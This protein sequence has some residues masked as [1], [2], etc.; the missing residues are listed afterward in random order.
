MKRAWG[1]DERF[2]EIRSLVWYT[3][4]MS[5]Q[6]VRDNLELHRETIKQYGIKRIGIFGS[7]ARNQDRPDSDI[8]LLLDF[9]PGEK[10][11]RNFFNGTTFLETLFSRPV[12]V[13]TPQALSHRFH[14]YIDQDITYVQIAD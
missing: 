11:Y 10:T 3:F 1:R 9:E 6:A 13:T 14:S 2:W 12:D 5:V 8:D 4:S 7:V